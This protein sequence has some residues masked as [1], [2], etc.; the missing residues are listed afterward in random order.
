MWT[1]PQALNLIRETQTAA[2]GFGYHICL[3]GSVLN[4]GQSKK[5]LDLYFLPLLSESLDPK[6]LIQSL[7]IGWGLSSGDTASW[8][9][10]EPGPYHYRLVFSGYGKT[11]PFPGKRVEVFIVGNHVL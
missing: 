8:T 7:E 11:H 3:G 9:N 1:L 4:A 2:K 6:S 5:D 10:P